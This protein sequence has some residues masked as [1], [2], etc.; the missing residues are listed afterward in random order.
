MCHLLRSHICP[1]LI[2]LGV[3]PYIESTDLVGT[4]QCC[5]HPSGGRHCHDRCRGESYTWIN[6]ASDDSCDF[7]SG[8]SG[9]HKPCKSYDWINCNYANFRAIGLC[10]RRSV[11]ICFVLNF[12]LKLNHNMPGHFMYVLPAHQKIQLTSHAGFLFSYLK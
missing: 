1:R 12:L 10:I 8:F 11:H 3:T 7:Q 4:G 2:F 5:K 9:Y 6:S